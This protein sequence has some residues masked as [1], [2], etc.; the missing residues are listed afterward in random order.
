MSPVQSPTDTPPAVVTT[1]Q[2]CNVA[3]TCEGFSLHTMEHFQGI[4]R[5][6]GKDFHQLVIHN[7]D[8][9]EKK[10]GAARFVSMC[11][12]MYNITKVNE[13]RYEKSLSN[14]FKILIVRPDDRMSVDAPNT[15]EWY[16]VNE[17]EFATKEAHLSL[18]KGGC[19]DEKIA[20]PNTLGDKVIGTIYEREIVGASILGDD[21]LLQKYIIKDLNLNK[22]FA[23]EIVPECPENYP[24]DIYL[25]WR[26]VKLMRGGQTNNQKPGIYN[27]KVCQSTK[28]KTIWHAAKKDIDHLHGMYLLSDA[29]L[30]WMYTPNPNG[31]S[32]G[33][34]VKVFPAFEYDLSQ[35]QLATKEI[36]L[37][38]NPIC[39]NIDGC[40]VEM[41]DQSFKQND[42]GTF[43]FE[44]I[45]C[46][47][48]K[49]TIR[50]IV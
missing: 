10:D 13:M 37:G 14:T 17:T 50:Y 31:G 6:N 19:P 25:V 18:S 44:K 38:E 43:T 7:V 28:A 22:K 2:P 32:I 42:N 40:H 11:G 24:S 3:L 15:Q 1:Q 30:K 8:T 12:K 29:P 39:Q 27:L 47:V 16:M 23:I 46:C 5:T 21:P 49:I 33:V 45:T 36:E 20:Q 9:K 35:F 4:F 34:K 26:G 41:F 48:P